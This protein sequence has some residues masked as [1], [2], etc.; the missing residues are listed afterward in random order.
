MLKITAGTKILVELKVTSQSVNEQKPN[1]LLYQPKKERWRH[2]IHVNC[3]MHYDVSLHSVYNNTTGL[4]IHTGS[5][6]D[7]S[8]YTSGFK[9]IA[10]EYKPV[11]TDRLRVSFSDVCCLVKK[12]VWDTRIGYVSLSTCSCVLCSLIVQEK[13]LVVREVLSNLKCFCETSSAWTHEN[14]ATHETTFGILAN[15]RLS[16]KQE[17]ARLVR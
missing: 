16:T 14:S 5:D 4:T 6:G 3:K 12:V 2:F 13:S 1:R 9:G 10:Y 8:K 17:T 7:L 15:L 11:C